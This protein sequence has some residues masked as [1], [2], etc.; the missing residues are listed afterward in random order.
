MNLRGFMH[1]A[2]LGKKTGVDLW[3][4]E[5]V[6]GRGI[7][8]ALDFLLPFAT[9]E[10]SWEYKQLGNLEDATEN[11]KINYLMAAE[12]TGEKKYASV[13][14]L[15]QSPEKNLETLIYPFPG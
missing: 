14:N 2:N 1:L 5:T 15:V 7:P 6:D 13:A 4:F 9:G 12:A 10:K 3:N 11:L 8:N